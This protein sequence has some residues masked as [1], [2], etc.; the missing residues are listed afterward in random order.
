[1]ERVER[2]EIVRRVILVVS[3][4]LDIAAEKITENS[5]FAYLGADSLDAVEIEMAVEEEFDID[6][7]WELEEALATV[8][9]VVD[10]VEVLTLERQAA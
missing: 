2:E 4:H 7:V 6:I 10:F 8:K 9:N 1:M 5:S 3:E